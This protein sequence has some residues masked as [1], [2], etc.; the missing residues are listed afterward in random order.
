MRTIANSTCAA[1]LKK[2]TNDQRLPKPPVK[3]DYGVMN[4][5]DLIAHLQLL[6]DRGAPP[7]TVVRIFD[8]DTSQWEHVTGSVI[9]TEGK[10]LDLYC[11]EN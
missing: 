8:V 3:E 5:T 9:C 10:T 7:D 11:D 1:T 4:I 2:A 6:L